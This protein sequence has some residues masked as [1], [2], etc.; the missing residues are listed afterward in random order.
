[1]FSS[2]VVFIG[3]NS[4]KPVE[5][6]TTADH[7]NLLRFFSAALDRDIAVRCVGADHH[8]RKLERK[9]LGNQ[10]EPVK[11]ASPFELRFV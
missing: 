5:V 7:V 1:M 4:A 9:P 8:V 3:G 2:P 11:D 6:R 10:Q